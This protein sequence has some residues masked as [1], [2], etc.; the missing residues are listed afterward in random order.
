MPT[1][2]VSDL[3]QRYTVI[4]MLSDSSR[5]FRGFT[6]QGTFGREFLKRTH[7]GRPAH[8]ADDTLSPSLVT[9]RVHCLESGA[10]DPDP[11]FHFVR[12]SL[13]DFVSSFCSPRGMSRS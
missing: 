13:S 10:R 11:R 8:A 1:G 3:R 12:G 4:W 7:N 6:T 2:R 9:H 5:S